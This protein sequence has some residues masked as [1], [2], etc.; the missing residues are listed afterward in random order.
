MTRKTFF[1]LAQHW[2][3][4][5]VRA[6][7][8]LDPSLARAV[9]GIGMTALHRCARTALVE[10]G[11]PA[12]AS[13]A[14]AQALLDAEAEVNAVREIDDDGEL[15]RATPLWYALAWGHNRELVRF[16]IGAGASAKGC[17]WAVAFQ[18]DLEMA[19]LLRPH[20]LELDARFA[21]KTALVESVIGKRFASVD[22]LLMRGADPNL[23]DDDGWTPLHHAV[24]RG[25]SVE[26]IS[27]LLAY[28]AS[29]DARAKDGSTP[30]ALARTLGKRRLVELFSA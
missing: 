15:F 10:G 14:T 17:V 2:Q 24:K 22:W 12:S 3:G 6:A 8:A 30:L 13:I 11:A 5:E 18:E 9:D 28:G 4:A 26:R 19:E 7:L 20:G 1:D 21:G 27:K 16:L 25:H 29:P 23:G